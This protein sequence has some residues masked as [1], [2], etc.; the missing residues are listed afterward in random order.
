MSDPNEYLRRLC[1]VSAQVIVRHPKE[2]P[3]D[4]GQHR[5]SF[6]ALPWWRKLHPRW[7]VTQ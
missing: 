7:A 1:T 6:D 2:V 4:Y 3:F 5:E